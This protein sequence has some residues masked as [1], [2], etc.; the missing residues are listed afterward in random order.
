MILKHIFVSC[1]CLFNLT[2]LQIYHKREYF[3]N[4][5]SVKYMCFGSLRYFCYIH[6]FSWGS[7]YDMKLFHWLFFGELICVFL[8]DIYSISLYVLYCFPPSTSFFFVIITKLLFPFVYLL[9][10][11]LHSLQTKK[12]L[13]PLWVLETWRSHQCLLPSPDIWALISQWKGKLL[14]GGVVLE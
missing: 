4:L 1:Y 13:H 9:Y 14:W 6:T 11:F 8:T 5:F 3:W 2:I 10:L 12:I 7:V